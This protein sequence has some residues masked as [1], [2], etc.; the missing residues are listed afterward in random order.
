MKVSTINETGVE[1]NSLRLVKYLAASGVASRR[2]A[3]ELVKN[4]EVLVNGKLP[5]G[6]GD[7]IH[8]DDNVT[9]KGKKV[10][11][12]PLYYL[13]LNKPRGYTCTNHDKHAEKKI[14]E[15]ID[16]PGN[17]KIFSA[18]RL[19]K[20]SEGMLIITNDGDYCDKL[21]HPRYEILKTYLV[22]VKPPISQAKLEI[23]RNG[24]MDEGEF[25]KPYRLEEITPGHY[26][27][28][29]NEGKK[30]EIRRLVRAGGAKTIKLKRVQIGALKLDVAPG[31]W[32]FIT[33]PEIAESLKK[34][35][36]R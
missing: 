21:S 10:T 7:L 29:L 33:P 22:T 14:F 20:E 28:I 12:N 11:L 5:V 15:L 27:F 2:K 16:L 35:L 32:R 31:K 1:S 8:P 17:P 3:G 24:I 34:G 6:P 18:G 19:D 30:R 9:W 25:L 23:L 36:C 13:M 26:R 4:G